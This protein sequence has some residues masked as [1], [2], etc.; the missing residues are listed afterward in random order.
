MPDLLT[1]KIPSDFLY[2]SKHN[3]ASS[4]F[5][6]RL[7]K[8]NLGLFGAPFFQIRVQGFLGG[9]RCNCSSA[10]VMKSGA[11]I[12]RDAPLATKEVAMGQGRRKNAGQRDRPCGDFDRHKLE[13][14]IQPPTG[15]A[16]AMP[17]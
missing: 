6:D 16:T 12:S 8:T 1:R 10:K 5:S 17:Y 4:L 14:H 13:L 2:L 9:R 15:L 3:N 7:G 11:S